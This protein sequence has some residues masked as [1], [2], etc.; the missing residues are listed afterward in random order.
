MHSFNGTLGLN[1]TSI[2]EITKVPRTTVLRKISF[3][4]KKG[5]L[6]KDEHKRYSSENIAKSSDTKKILSLMNYNVELLGFFFSQC[7]E[8]YSKKY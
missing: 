6:K 3:L 4:E 5:M 2:A 1:A 7:L 8:T